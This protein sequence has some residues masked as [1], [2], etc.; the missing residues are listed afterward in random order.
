MESSVTIINFDVLDRA[1]ARYFSRQHIQ[2]AMA[3]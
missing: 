3:L 1:F 2:V